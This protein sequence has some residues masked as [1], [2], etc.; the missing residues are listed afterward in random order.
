MRRSRARSR[1]RST[2]VSG[3]ELR[4]GGRGLHDREGSTEPLI[5]ADEGRDTGAPPSEHEQRVEGNETQR[6]AADL[7]PV[8]VRPQPVRLVPAAELL[9]CDRSADDRGELTAEI[10]LRQLPSVENLEERAFVRSKASVALSPKTARCD[11][12]PAMKADR[13][14][15]SSGRS[16]IVKIATSFVGTQPTMA[17]SE[18][19]DH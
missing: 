5:G 7:L 15:S 18:R 17:M 13:P 16:P 11:D 6:P 14:S 2:A 3:Q 19:W 9:R 10:V 4:P 12:A 8:A 1:V